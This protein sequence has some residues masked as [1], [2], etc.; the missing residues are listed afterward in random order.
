MKHI[1][2]E[3]IRKQNIPDILSAVQET[4][5]NEKLDIIIRLL[6][7]YDSDIICRALQIYKEE[8]L[9]LNKIDNI[10]LKIRLSH[11]CK[12]LQDNIKGEI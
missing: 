10:P 1:Y 11:Q 9:D 7:H 6:D 2:E 8:Y 12:I 4:S 5:Y 3:M